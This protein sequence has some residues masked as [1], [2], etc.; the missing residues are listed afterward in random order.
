LY[1][2]FEMPVEAGTE[3]IRLDAR[4]CSDF[5]QESGLGICC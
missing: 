1:I 2:V 5:A 3:V 4:L